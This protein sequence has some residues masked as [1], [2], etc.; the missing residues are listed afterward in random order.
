V[1][2]PHPPWIVA[3]R[4]ALPLL[5]NTIPALLRAVGEA[6]DML[7]FD[8]QATADDVLVLA[9]DADL[10][11]LA[12]RPDLVVENAKQSELALL[13]LRDPLYPDRTGRLPTLAALLTAIPEGFPVNIE[14]KVGRSDRGRLAALALEAVS[15]RPNVLFSTFD[16]DLLRE[17]R[18]RSATAR[19]AA[20]AERWTPGVAA[21][22]AEI[23]A[24]SLHVAAGVTEARAAAAGRQAGAPEPP[25]PPG[26]PGLSSPPPPILVYTV[27]DPASAREFLAQ[28]AT[29]LFSDRPGPLRAELG[30]PG[31]SG[32]LSTTYRGR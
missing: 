28:G 17:L 13:E 8:V 30:M 4:G 21:L 32:V 10:G 23:G 29:G 2:L 18:R 1:R 12:A 7:E 25:A 5:E 3:H 11:R 19:L 14:L 22:G 6:A 20:L 15:G 31:D 26:L 27:N 24:W 16:A 9:H